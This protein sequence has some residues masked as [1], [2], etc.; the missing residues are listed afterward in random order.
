LGLLVQEALIVDDS[1]TARAILRNKLLKQNIAVA[2]VESGE[3]ALLYLRDNHPD[4]IFMDHMMPG[5][6]GFDAVKAIKSNPKNS[7]IPIVMHTTKQGDIYIGQAKALGAADIL[8]KP[9]TDQDLLKVL[10]RLRA[11]AKNIKNSEPRV[12]IV[13]L[14]QDG[15]QVFQD[16]N[17]DTEFNGDTQQKREGNAKLNRPS[18]LVSTHSNGSAFIDAPFQGEG[19]DKNMDAEV[20]F[21]GTFRQWLIATIW[22]FPIVW[23]LW[24][25]L[26]AQEQLSANVIEKQELYRTIQWVLNK[27]ASYDYGEIP[28]SGARLGLL[29]DLVPQLATANFEGVVQMEGHVGAFCLSQVLLDDGSPISML[30]EY[31]LPVSECTSIGSSVR[32]ALQLS[33]KES[34]E[35][36]RFLESATSLYPKIRIEIIP[37]GAS[38][39]AYSYPAD[40]DSV[41]AGVWNEIALANNRVRFTLLPAIPIF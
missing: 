6:D 3:E 4:M 26:P 22:L 16:N 15:D 37:L 34:P 7:S 8:P 23:L 14:D 35:F 28:N 40:L 36:S 31:D 5:M 10:D 24:L 9:G 29:Q 25:Y 11:A 39:P 38:Q 33:V 18:P 27:Q 2:M 12:E 30:P 20:P 21:L 41:T 19:R 32:Q 13:S 1:K 17:K